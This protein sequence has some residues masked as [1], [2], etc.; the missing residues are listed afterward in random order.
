MITIGTEIDFSLVQ[1]YRATLLY[2]NLQCAL[3]R[4]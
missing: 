2:R 4:D 3:K 1:L